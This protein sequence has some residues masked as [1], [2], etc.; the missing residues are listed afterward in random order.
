MCIDFRK[1]NAITRKDRFPIPFI[2]EMLERLAG[3][4]FFYF[5][6]GFSSYYQIIVAYEDQEKTTFTCPFGTFF[7]RCMP[8]GL[9]N[10]PSTFQRCMMSIFSYL[11]ENCID[12]TVYGNSFYQCLDHLTKVLK[13]CINTNLV[14]NYEKYH[15]M[16]Q[17]GIV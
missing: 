6:N 2:D 15:F 16:V 7:Y 8:F 3:N 10:A 12:F 14:L 5:L 17:Q 4:S 13:R 11:I 9:C 1:L